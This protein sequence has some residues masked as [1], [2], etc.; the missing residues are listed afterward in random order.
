[1]KLASMSDRIHTAGAEVIAI[2][3]DDDDRAAAMFARWPT[4]HVQYIS[5]PG[6]STYLRPMDMF[7]PEE[8]GG[9]ALPGLFVLDSAGNEVFGYR[10]NDFADRRDDKDV[11]AA[12]DRL[13]LDPI[14]SPDG[15][16]VVNDVD[17][18][19]RGAFSPKM[20]GPY[21]SGNKFG[22][23]AIRLRA[24]GN[25]AKTLATEHQQMSESMLE[26]WADVNG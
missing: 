4:P 21:F 1:V 2:S 9:I 5:D 7:D 14:E 24:E 3:V 13:G 26:A 19:Q 22:A 15:G 6:G 17:V 20:F 16:P 12:L 25:E 23:L 18:N 11:M 8:R 10:G